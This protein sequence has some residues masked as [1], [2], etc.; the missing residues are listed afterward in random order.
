MR[1]ESGFTLLEVLV[2]TA[3]PAQTKSQNLF[4]SPELGRS[5]R[6]SYRNWSWRVRKGR[7]VPAEGNATAYPILIPKR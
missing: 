5:R 2:A 6:N 7:Q 3:I 4:V 1:R